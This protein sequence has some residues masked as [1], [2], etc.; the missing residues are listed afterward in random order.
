MA[1]PKNEWNAMWSGL[2]K[3]MKEDSD[4]FTVETEDGAKTNLVVWFLV[5]LLVGCIPVGAMVCNH[6]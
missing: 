2:R 3:G 4:F 1:E 6:P 5:M